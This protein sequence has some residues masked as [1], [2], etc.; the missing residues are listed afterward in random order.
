MKKK[1]IIKEMNK[2][3]LGRLVLIQEHPLFGM[4]IAGAKLEESKMMPTLYVEYGAYPEGGIQVKVFYNENFIEKLSI[5]EIAG[6]LFHEISHL[7]LGHTSERY[8]NY[9]KT[10]WNIATDYVVN[11]I[12]KNHSNLPLLEGALYNPQFKG[13]CAE[14]IYKLLKNENKSSGSSKS[15]KSQNA[16]GEVEK[17]SDL[18]VVK[19]DKK[20]PNLIL[21]ISLVLENLGVI[22]PLN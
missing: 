9:D 15:E 4:L 2:I 13:M 14:E 19:G 6:C 11:D 12:L 3:E 18:P 7:F 17:G 8:E 16:K 21:P 22:T 5:S 20:W 1:E 10:L